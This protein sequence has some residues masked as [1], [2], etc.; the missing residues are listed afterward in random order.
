MNIKVFGELLFERDQKDPLLDHI[1]I[2]IY[3]LLKKHIQTLISANLNRKEI[4]NDIKTLIF[5]CVKKRYLN[6]EN[7]TYIMRNYICDCISI[8]IISG[9]TCCWNTCI[10][11]LIKEAKSGNSELI[12]IALRSIADC[13]LIMNFYESENDDN[14]WDDNLYFKENE[15][16]E[17]KNIL[18]DK[19]ELVFSFINEIYGIINKFEKKLKNRII[20]SIIDLVTFWTKLNLNILTNQQIYT[21][22]MDLV[23]M[24][25]E[26]KDKIENLK[27]M[28]ELINTSI[29]SSRNCK[30]YEFYDKVNDYITPNETLQNI[31]DNIDINEKNGI[32]NCLDYIL[33]KI[34]EYN[35]VKNKNENIIWIYAKILSS[36]LENYI[37]FFFDFNNERNINIFNLLKY[38]ISHKKRKISWMF[39]N[40]IDNMMIFISDYYKFYGVNDNHIKQFV[41]YLIE[42][43]L[44]I[45]DNCALPKFNPNDYSQLL[46]LILFRDNESNW[47]LTDKNYFYNNMNND[48]DFDLDDIDIK[49]Y[50][51]SA[52][53]VFYCIYTIF[54]EGLNSEY[55]KYFIN[56]ILSLINIKD[57]KVKNNY[58]EKNAKILDVILLVLKSILVGFDVE[59]SP[60]IVLLINEYI[61]YLSD[62]IYIQNINTNIFID[63]LILINQIGNILITEQK[64]FEKA[65]LIL[66]LV[67]D[68]KDVNQYLIDS[69]YKVISNLCGD[70]TG[71][72]NY[73]KIFD[74]FSERFKK[75]YNI[76]N[77]NNI[78]PLENLI[79]SMFYVIG[80]NRN[81][82]TEI[83]ETDENIITYI[84]KIL[85]PINNNLKLNLYEDN[86]ININNLKSEIIKVFLLYKV[87]FYNIHYSND[88][89]RKII[90]NDFI[91]KSIK[92][93]VK[94]F[95]IFPNDM[96]IF[97]PIKNFYISNAISICEDCLSNFSAINEVF[98][99]L[100]K[101]NVNYFEI[102]DFLETIYSHVLKKLNK[103]DNNY[104]EQNKF[105]LD[106]FFILI[107]YSIQYIKK[108][109]NFDEQF[110][111][112]IKL[113]TTTINDVFPLLY[114][115]VEKSDT[116]KNI[117]NVVLEIFVF[118]INII[119]LIINNKEK[120][121][122][123]SD[124]IISFI[125]KSINSLFNDN[126]IK[127]LLDNLS[128][129]QNE[130]LINKILLSTWKLLNI[131]NFKFL[132]CQELCSLYY[133]T[134]LLNY[135]T[136]SKYFAN[137]LNSSGLFSDKEYINNIYNY[138]LFFYK[139]K[140]KVIGFIKEILL[141]VYDNKNIDCLS[142]YFNQL[143]RKKKL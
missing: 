26:D 99:E 63:Y 65:F 11:D 89:I 7:P 84:N 112:K 16:K 125:I 18:M 100:F 85:E 129:E 17:I 107:K 93:L 90:F 53:H 4:Y 130:E 114:F 126:I 61:Y 73:G 101:L 44:N 15:K 13:D 80:I 24:I 66:L 86:N 45:M 78:S 95:S 108:E 128:R 9:I 76:Y 109:S 6:L 72:I 113:F 62:S 49:E 25:E 88:S 79:N 58:D 83:F 122:L 3:G 118:L 81:N 47:E 59:S 139:D 28:A 67:S 133:Q 121:D 87:I 141:I 68:R 1:I 116:I 96:D 75:I 102:I 77:I 23:N 135:E 132:S 34:N 31:Q 117:I 119:D 2:C 134:I 69:C 29:I 51:N 98:I 12:F 131:P 92:D 41:E 19:S 91:T 106:N 124:N 120:Q 37:Y 35:N 60:E 55:E 74:I 123:I 32:N 115:P 21:T 30:I 10:E 140:D 48:D 142:Y 27:S 82:G 39:F 36:F 64:Y 42:L 137:C 20:K 57:E 105:M 46:K 56:R 94:I 136:F 143:N 22:I 40:S 97:T 54:K 8:L 103:N 50:R 38:F 127:C 138:I 111:N 43:L 71:K 104:N 110:L 33:Q 52:E 14:Y 70:L 5:E